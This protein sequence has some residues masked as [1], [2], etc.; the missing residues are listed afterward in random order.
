MRCDGYHCAAPPSG[1]FYLQMVGDAGPK[2]A[3]YSAPD[4]EGTEAHPER[5]AIFARSASVLMNAAS[6]S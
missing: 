2:L 3:N 1:A 6:K 4:G 5:A